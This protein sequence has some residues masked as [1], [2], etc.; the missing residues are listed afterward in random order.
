M[1][2]IF[3]FIG[4]QAG[5]KSNT[6]LYAKNILD[7]VVEKSHETI[8]IDFYT[9][10]K[11]KINSC[12][13]CNNC[14]LTCSCPLDESDD[15]RSLKEKMINAD[16]IIWGTPIYA[17]NV[18]GDMKIFIDRLS[19]WMH[20]MR[21]AGKAGVVITTTSY[22]GSTFTAAYL[23]KIMNNTGIRVIGKFNFIPH[24][25]EEHMDKGASQDDYEQCADI[26]LEY[27]SGKKAIGSDEKLESIFQSYKKVMMNP[28]RTQSAEYHYWLENGYLSCN[29]FDEVIKKMNSSKKCC[30]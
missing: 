15:M 17:H 28:V 20:L 27:F 26:I 1:I 18:S 2:K 10:D 19:Y 13:S 12:R 8:E 22:S 21:L 16:S 30:G 25:I 11:I 29:N 4:S 6:A 9:A 3:T 24:L 5:N 14:F 7:K 23:E